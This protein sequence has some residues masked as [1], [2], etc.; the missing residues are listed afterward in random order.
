MTSPDATPM[1]EPARAAPATEP[2]AA[3]NLYPVIPIAPDAMLTQ[4]IERA[5][6]PSLTKIVETHAAEGQ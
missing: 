5:E 4:I 6:Q 3:T 1:T 2:A